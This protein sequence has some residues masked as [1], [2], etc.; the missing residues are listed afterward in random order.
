MHKLLQLLSCSNIFNIPP[1]P[2]PSEIKCVHYSLPIE[3]LHDMTAIELNYLLLLSHIDTQIE[4]FTFGHNHPIIFLRLCMLFLL[5]QMCPFLSI[6]YPSTFNSCFISSRKPVP[7]LSQLST[8][9]CSS[10]NVG[11]HILICN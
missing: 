2:T 7:F 11:Y 4:I 1:Q 8:A 9:I 6:S 3:L 10:F 5:S